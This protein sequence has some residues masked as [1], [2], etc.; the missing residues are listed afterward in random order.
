MR[1]FI[2]HHSG[3][4]LLAW[5]GSVAIGTGLGAWALSWGAPLL[6]VLC[7]Q[8]ALQI[9]LA[10]AVAHGV[11]ERVGGLVAITLSM[12]LPFGAFVGWAQVALSRATSSATVVAA[13]GAALVGVAV[14]RAFGSRE[15]ESSAVRPVVLSAR[16]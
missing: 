4:F 6:V 14:L 5:L 15:R 11:P 12:M 7:A 3:S 8:L 1:D 10:L 13:L 2:V 9:T 16:G